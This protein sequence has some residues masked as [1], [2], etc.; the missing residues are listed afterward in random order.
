MPEVEMAL[1]ITE[2]HLKTLW[3]STDPKDIDESIQVMKKI[4]VIAK[5]YNVATNIGR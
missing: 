4:Q 5:Q 3:S 1:G 2:E